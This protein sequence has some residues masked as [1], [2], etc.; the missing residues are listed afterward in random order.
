MKRVTRA[1]LEA[2]VARL[3]AADGQAQPS[4][5]TFP[6]RPAPSRSPTSPA[7]PLPAPDFGGE[8]NANRTSGLGSPSDRS[9]ESA[10][11]PPG[12]T[13]APAAAW[14]G[15]DRSAAVQPSIAGVPARHDPPPEPNPRPL[16]VGFRQP[17]GAGVDV[18][19][20]GA[21]AEAIEEAAGRRRPMS[22]LTA[23]LHRHRWHRPRARRVPRSARTAVA[24]IY[25]LP[26]AVVEGMAARIEAAI[27]PAATAEGKREI[28]AARGRSSGAVRRARCRER[29][30]QAVYAVRRGMPVREVAA[31]LRCSPATVVGA[32]ARLQAGQRE[33]ADWRRA[34]RERKRAVRRFWRDHYNREH[35]ETCRCQDGARRR[36]EQ[37]R[38]AGSPAAAVP[39]VA[40]TEAALRLTRAERRRFDQRSRGVSGGDRRTLS[41]R[42]HVRVKAGADAPRSSA[43]NGRRE[44]GD[45]PADREREQLQLDPATAAARQRCL[46]VLD[47]IDARI[48]AD[49]ERERRRRRSPRRPGS[50]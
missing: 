2:W 22:D 23:A 31:A 45:S 17:A 40:A 15:A 24:A 46:E 39:G 14:E 3:A 38:R 35:G 19:V 49:R 43:G 29:D 36:R 21:H 12:A 28:Q 27:P 47:R 8:G 25:G 33:D 26:R 41:L 16:P 48:K 37:G 30:V 32:A 7:L 18:A 5:P 20:S 9:A 1:E 6:P 50:G 13:S 34:R 42:D 4:L 11:P 10:P 44:S